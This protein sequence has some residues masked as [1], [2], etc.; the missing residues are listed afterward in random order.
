M[1]PVDRS[2]RF[3]TDEAL[4]AG[5]VDGDPDAIAALY[6]QYARTIRRVLRRALGVDPEV[7]DLTHDA[8]LR[9]VRDIANLEDP[10]RLG[11][12]LRTIAIFTARGHLR[13]RARRRALKALFRGDLEPR[14]ESGPDDRAHEV[15]RETYRALDA[16]AADERLAFTL[17]FIEGLELTEVASTCQVSLATIKRRLA[18]ASTRFAAIARENEVLREWIERGTR[19][20][21]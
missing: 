9:A 1:T 18:R 19:W 8:L 3:A 7:A 4:V 17:R 21:T 5:L 15:L 6:D 2:S 11:G 10:S 12:W 20:K 16:L 14:I 13:R